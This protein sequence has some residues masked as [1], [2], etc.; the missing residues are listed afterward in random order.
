MRGGTHMLTHV[1]P[2]VLPTVNRPYKLNSKYTYSTLLP[3][4]L[5]GC[6]VYAS[7]TQGQFQLITSAILVD[8]SK[9]FNYTSYLFSTK[10]EKT[11]LSRDE[12][13]HELGLG[14]KR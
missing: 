7:A 4:F 5:F 3:A 13:F 10:V 1:H 9:S 12:C 2:F 8:L 6:V 14:N 11:T